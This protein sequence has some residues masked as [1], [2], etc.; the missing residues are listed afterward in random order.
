MEDLQKSM[1]E[2]MA[3]HE[4]EVACLVAGDFGDSP[5]LNVR[6]E[7]ARKKKDS[8]IELYKEHVTSHG[9]YPRK[10]GPGASAPHLE[11]FFQLAAN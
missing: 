1:V 2:I 10:L 7:A 3:I 9:C 5:D 4:S 8:L 11:R 6:L